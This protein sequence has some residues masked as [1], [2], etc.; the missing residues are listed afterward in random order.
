MADEYPRPDF[1]RTALRWKSLDG[2]WALVFDDA[3]AGLERGWQHQG[4]PSDA[5]DGAARRRE[6]RVPYAFQTPASGIGVVEAHEVV[7]YERLVADVRT[8]DEVARGYRLLARFGAVDY[9]CEAWL[10]GRPVGGHQG[11]H[12]PFDLDLTDAVRAASSSSPGSA[13]QQFRLTM[14]VR[15]SPGDL[16]QPRGKQ[17]WKPVSEEIFY[18]PTTGIWL[19]V[20]LESV[21]PARLAD[22]S[23]GTVL[24]SDDIDAGQLHAHVVVAGRRAGHAY[25]VEIETSLGGVS[26]GRA[27]AAVAAEKDYAELDVDMHVADREAAS[28]AVVSLS[29]EGAWHTNGVA[30]WAPEHPTLYDIVLRLR[31][32]GEVVDE[33]R[34]T[35]GMR[36]LSWQ[37]GDRAVRLNGRPL[38]QALVLDQGYWPETGMTP[39]SSEALRADIEMAMALGFNGCRKHQKVEDPRF[40][41][42]ADRLGF[43]VWGEMASAFEFGEAYA[44]RFPREWIAAVRRD[45]SRPSIITWTPAN[46]SWGY[47]D[48]DGSRRQRDHLRALVYATK[49]LDPTRP[50]N[51]NCGWEHVATDLTTYHDYTDAP[52]L[53][54][55]CKRMDGGILAPKNGGGRGHVVFT[56]PISGKNGEVLDPGQQLDPG[57]PVL[58]TEFGGVNIA[59]AARKAAGDAAG[60][61]D[62]GY[63]TASDPND[64]LRRFE[65]L[66]MAIVRGGHTCGFV[67][68]QL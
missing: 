28:G 36:K 54:E 34:T 41:H 60:E 6:I 65:S 50:I 37:Q 67:Y 49:A 45:I 42:W 21:P 56:G 57:A 35:T 19:S 23:G 46:E 30:L 5:A 44:D 33:V 14:R 64:L 26:V 40:L 11:G 2:P 3:D 53:A 66:L 52:V 58:C 63:T 12:V 7:W 43:L 39:P 51:D 55:T 32:S 8:A 47:P 62:W 38:F 25:T 1:Q 10:D 59:P 18:A 22:G 24:R 68:T 9:E 20:W 27:S 16:E 31:E 48:L 15:D 4:L 13:P 17:Y 29:A 61:R